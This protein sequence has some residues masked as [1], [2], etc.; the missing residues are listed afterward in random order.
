M[1]RARI[2]AGGKLTEY[3]AE[4]AEFVFHDKVGHVVRQSSIVTGRGLH[5]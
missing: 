2:S 1:K 5:P 3:A 4:Y